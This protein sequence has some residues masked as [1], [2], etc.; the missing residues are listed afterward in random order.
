MGNVTIRV[1][2]HSGPVVASVVG[3]RNP[4][5]CLFGDSMNLAS[6]ME[7]TSE[8]GRIQCSQFSCDLARKQ[9][10]DLKFVFRGRIKVKGKG[11][12]AVFFVGDEK[13][14]DA[15]QESITSRHDDE[16]LKSTRSITPNADE[17]KSTSERRKTYTNTGEA[18]A[19]AGISN[20]FRDELSDD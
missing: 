14:M 1:G 6:R 5:Y 2:F 3:T 9:D 18:R 7:S 15:I 4:R 13:D 19:L 8:A 20:H 12:M 11:R 17:P 10:A 16:C